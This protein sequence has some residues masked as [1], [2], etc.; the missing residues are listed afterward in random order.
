[1]FDISSSS[2]ESTTALRLVATR[3]DVRTGSVPDMV[4]GCAKLSVASPKE[5]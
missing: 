3:L 4:V 5:S 1:M 2:S